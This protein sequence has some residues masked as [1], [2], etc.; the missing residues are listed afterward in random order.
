MH[1][2]LHGDSGRW[3]INGMRELV[4]EGC[5][6]EQSIDGKMER[7]HRACMEQGVISMQQHHSSIENK[8]CFRSPTVVLNGM[9]S[10][11]SGLPA[12]RGP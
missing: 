9:P 6:K 10:K 11:P 1:T 12:G 4:K 5:D 8:D 7:N 2:R 3:Y